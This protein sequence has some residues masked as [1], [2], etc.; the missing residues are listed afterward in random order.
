MTP[1]IESPN[2]DGRGRH[3]AIVHESTDLR[4]V[5]ALAAARASTP[6][7]PL[8]AVFMEDSLAN[9]FHDDPLT[10]A[11][12]WSPVLASSISAALPP[13]P[14]N[15][16]APP[17]IVIGDGAIGRMIAQAYVEDWSEPGQPLMLHCIGAAADWAQEASAETAPRGQ[18]TWSALPLRPAPIVRRVTDLIKQWDRPKPKHAT[19]V[20]PSVIVALDAPEVG[21]PIGAA[22]A[23]EV[24]DARVGVV[25]E[26]ASIWPTL[27]GVTV[28]SMKDARQLAIA[29][30]GRPMD[31]LLDLLL[32]DTAWLDTP[33]AHVTRPRVR[34]LDPV[35]RDATGS[36]LPFEEQPQRLRTSLGA[37]AEAIRP[38]LAVGNLR[39]AGSP[40][41]DASPVILTPGELGAMATEI[42][43]VLDVPLSPDARLTALELAFRLPSLVTRSGRTVTRPAGYQQLLSSETVELLAPLVHLA[44][45]NV[46]VQTDHASGSPLAF[47]MWEQLSD[48]YRMSNRAVV[49]GCAV[50]HAAEGLGWRSSAS[51]SLPNWSAE[52]LERLAELEHRRW[53]IH[54]R[55]N[56]AGD[57]TWMQPW[58]ELD[59]GMKDYDRHIMRAM[60]AILADARIEVIQDA[61]AAPEPARLS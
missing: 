5:Q 7:Q 46:S 15:R 49:V 8:T 33:D 3:D 36:G 61:S 56:G 40:R 52:R 35:S 31:R 17:P 19:P 30:R 41:M 23:R 11:V 38:I 25:V 32:A 39:L 43:R 24:E 47:E 37:V 20:G 42:L 9:L 21:M 13:N 51:P 57:H 14:A 34:L 50:A 60:P 58:D 6:D 44:Y 10:T 59:E 1:P 22:I 27:A 48:F 29:H 4:T 54:Q 53:A 16:I 18:L 12:A 55:R 45:Q 26:D 2:N 28:F